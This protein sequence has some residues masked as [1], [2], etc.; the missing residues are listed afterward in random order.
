M[1]IS[2][3]STAIA[4]VERTDDIRKEV[5]SSSDAMMVAYTMS[6]RAKKS[7]SINLVK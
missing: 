7:I 2:P 3:T 4:S 5:K 1:T 6:A